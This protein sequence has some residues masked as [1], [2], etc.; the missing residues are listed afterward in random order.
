[1][2][3]VSQQAMDEQ[4]VAVSSLTVPA[5][6]QIPLLLPDSR[7]PCSDS[8]SHSPQFYVDT[9]QERTSD[10]EQMRILERHVENDDESRLTRPETLD[11][12]S[13]SPIAANS[14]STPKTDEPVGEGIVAGV[15][16]ETK[17]D[18]SRSGKAT[19]RL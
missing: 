18:V 11:L 4:S 9:R 1:M 6:Q 19:S 2:I 13:T 12:S 7:S 14:K 5:H 10:S 17:N 15:V 8:D 16:D 3:F